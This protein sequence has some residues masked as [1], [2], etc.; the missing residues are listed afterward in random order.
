[1]RNRGEGG[2]SHCVI[3]QNIFCP[4]GKSGK[5]AQKCAYNYKKESIQGM[6]QWQIGFI[7]IDRIIDLTA[8]VDC[9]NHVECS[10]C[11]NRMISGL[12]EPFA[13]SPKKN[14]KWNNSILYIFY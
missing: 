6:N 10:N 1:M 11:V 12:F 8:L 14:T 5:M 7:W 13:F 2:S 3:T 9:S 4:K